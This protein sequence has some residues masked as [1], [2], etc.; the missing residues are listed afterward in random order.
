LGLKRVSRTLRCMR[1]QGQMKRA[2]G[3]DECCGG[4]RA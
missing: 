4:V 1:L 3:G 2:A